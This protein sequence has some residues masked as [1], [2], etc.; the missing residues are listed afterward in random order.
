MAFQ[1]INPFTSEK[2]N[3]FPYDSPEQLREKIDQAHLVF[4]EWKTLRFEARGAL[5]LQLAENIRK[6]LDELALTISREMGK[7]LQE[8]KAELEK[9]AL[10]AEYYAKES[11]K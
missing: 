8:S 6:Q 5:F 7:P 3:D 4:Q 1:S 11:E 9:C 2:L 10:T